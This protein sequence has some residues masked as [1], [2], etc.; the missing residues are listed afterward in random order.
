[1]K[2]TLVLVL[3]ALSAGSI[4]VSAGAVPESRNGRIAFMR[5]GVND[6]I[7]TVKP[8]GTQLRRVTKSPANRQDYNPT[9]SP[10]GSMVLF[11]RRNLQAAGD[12]LYTVGWNGAGLHRLT[13]CSTIATC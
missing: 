12:D 3:A 6:G 13:G 2:T 1:L 4:A 8:D 10:N 7:W 5:Y 11:E 9:W